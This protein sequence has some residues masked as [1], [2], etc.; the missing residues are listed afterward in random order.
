M[1]VSP[2]VRNTLPKYD[3]MWTDKFHTFRRNLLP[4]FHITAVSYHLRSPF[5]LFTPYVVYDNT[6]ILGVSKLILLEES[7]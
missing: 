2:T 6:P 3:A 1:Y 4:A 5:R 7:A